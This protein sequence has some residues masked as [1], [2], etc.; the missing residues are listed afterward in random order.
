[1]E[2]STLVGWFFL[3]VGFL[4]YTLAVWGTG[5]N[6][7][8]KINDEDRSRGEVGN[9]DAYIASLVFVFV[10]LFVYTVSSLY[11]GAKASKALLQ[12]GACQVTALT[13]SSY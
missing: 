11:T 7:Q 1:M 10:G 3:I 12:S 2:V 6:Q 4:T 13:R 9:T 5:Y 8:R